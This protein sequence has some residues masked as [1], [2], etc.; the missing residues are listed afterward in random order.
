MLMVFFN[1][2]IAETYGDIDGATD[3][4]EYMDSWS[5]KGLMEH[6]LFQMKIA[7]TI[8]QLHGIRIVCILLM[9]RANSTIG[10]S[11]NV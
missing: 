9:K 5:Y 7:P 8:Q 10:S 3:D 1:G 11:S 4:W 6:G 2:D